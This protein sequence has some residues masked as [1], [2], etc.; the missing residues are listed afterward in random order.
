MQQLWFLQVSPVWLNLTAAVHDWLQ[1]EVASVYRH[2]SDCLVRN[3]AVEIELLEQECLWP[4]L[5]AFVLSD[6]RLYS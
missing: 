1:L 5:P 2:R 4:W 6:W 3:Y